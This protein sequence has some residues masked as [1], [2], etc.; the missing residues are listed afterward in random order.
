MQIVTSLRGSSNLHQIFL[1]A[2]SI[3]LYVWADIIPESQAKLTASLGTQ[4]NPKYKVRKANVL[5]AVCA[6]GAPAHRQCYKEGSGELELI[7]SAQGDVLSSGKV[8]WQGNVFTSSEFLRQGDVWAVNTI[9]SF[10]NDTVTRVPDPR[11]RP[12]C[13][14]DFT[15][16]PHVLII[17]QLST[18]SR[19]TYLQVSFQTVRMACK[20]KSWP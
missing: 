18:S 20:A 16:H 7:S 17:R 4:A 2:W 19:G 3:E 11:T 12:T 5:C 10:V 6:W 13:T 9:L 14:S 15:H 8:L 1:W